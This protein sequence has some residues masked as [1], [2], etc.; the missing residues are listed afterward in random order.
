MLTLENII[1]EQHAVRTFAQYRTTDGA[2]RRV[3]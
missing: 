3:Y 2:E 1:D